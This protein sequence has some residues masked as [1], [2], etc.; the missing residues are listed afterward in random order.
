LQA[1]RKILVQIKNTPIAAGKHLSVALPRQQS[2]GVLRGHHW[3]VPVVALE[4]AVIVAELAA[5]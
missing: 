3:P 2:A 5:C 1:P 4:P